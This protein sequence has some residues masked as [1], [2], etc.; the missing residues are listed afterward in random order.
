VRT[1]GE[2]SNSPYV[3]AVVGVV[4][5]GSVVEVVDAAEITVAP[6]AVVLGAEV[7]RVHPAATIRS[8]VAI[9]SRFIGSPCRVLLRLP[10]EKWYGRR[11]AL[12]YG[13]ERFSRCFA[14]I[15]RGFSNPVPS[16]TCRPPP[17]SFCS[18]PG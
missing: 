16:R 6:F 2:I 13:S 9:A 18:S 17:S 15:L 3:P 12:G 4:E 5:V 11:R 7:F 14:K 1:S 8:A 10:R